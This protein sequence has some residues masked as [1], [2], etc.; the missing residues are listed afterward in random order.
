MYSTEN[1]G[2]HWTKIF[3]HDV[4]SLALD[5]SDERM[6][7]AGT[8]PVHLFRSEDSGAHWEELTGLNDLPSEVRARQVYPVPGEHSHILSIFIDPDNSDTIVLSVEHGGVLRSLS[9]F[10]PGPAMR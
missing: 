3:N 5:P 6:I 1:G 7:Y 9:P 10:T 4:W 8:A 2:W